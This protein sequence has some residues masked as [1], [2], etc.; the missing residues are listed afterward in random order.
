M[1]SDLVDI[2]DCVIPEAKRRK[3]TGRARFVVDVVNRLTKPSSPGEDKQAVFEK[4]IDSSIEHTLDGLRRSVRSILASDQSG[5]MA[6]LL[7]RMVLAYHLHGGKISFA[8]KDQADFVDKALCKLRP[9]PDGIHLVMDEP[10][11]VEA[12]EIELKACGKDPAFTEYL[13]QIFQVVTNFGLATTSKGDAFEPLVRRC[14]QRFNGY[15]IADLPFLQGIKL[16][17]WCDN[18]TLQIDTINT[19]NGYGYTDTGLRADLAFLK[20]CPLNQMLI[21]QFGT[22]PDGLWFFS[23][24]HYA[25]S[26][27]IKLYSDKISKDLL[28]SNETSSDVRGCFLGKDGISVSKANAAI[29]QEFLASGTPANLKGVLRIHIELPGISGGDPATYIKTDPVTNTEDVM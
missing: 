19:A 9:H 14:L 23:D 11:V 2:D 15:R 13:D 5:S 4:A 6:R 7:S 22:R 26:L 21:A 27:A 10:M 3:L 25:G 28:R 16:P 17:A 29:R 8:G 12:V 24:Y 18:L 1:L 20:D